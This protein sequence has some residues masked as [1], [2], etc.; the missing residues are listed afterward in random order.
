MRNSYTVL[1]ENLTIRDKLRDIRADWKIILNSNFKNESEDCINLAKDKVG[2][3]RLRAK[4]TE[5]KD[6]LQ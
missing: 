2:I 3:V 1:V 6:K 4:T 5:F